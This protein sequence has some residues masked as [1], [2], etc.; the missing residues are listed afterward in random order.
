VFSLQ[1]AT[2]N[3]FLMEYITAGGFHRQDLP[4]TLLPEAIAMR[5]A[6]FAD[7]AALGTQIFTTHD[8]RLG[9][10]EYAFESI[11]ID[12]TTD[13][14]V[15]WC[16][17]LT[18]CD[19]ALVI[20]PESDDLLSDM[21]QLLEHTTAINLG[22]SHEAV[23]LASNKWF[24]YQ[25]FI[26][27]NIPTT[28]TYLLD[29][30]V[31][32]KGLQANQAYILKPKD[33]AG[34]ERTCLFPSLVAVM[35]WLESNEQSQQ[36][37]ILQPYITGE[38]A[39]FTML[40]KAGQAVVLSCN[41]QTIQIHQL[42]E[43]NHHIL[44]YHGGVVNAKPDLHDA[45]LTLAQ[46]IAMSCHGFNGLLGVDVI[47]QYS[48]RGELKHID[49]VEINPRITTSYVGLHA[50]IARNPAQLILDNLKDGLTFLY[51]HSTTKPIEILL[52]G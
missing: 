8:V 20:A 17:L 2:L 13:I 36:D 24:T 31:I 35:V 32:I 50:S 40:C 28:T 18:R 43:T 30:L 37:Y 6:I 19:Y 22:C 29:D 1:K 48:Q 4:M 52:N 11:A 12:N 23:V 44:Q 16:A 41:T 42:A 9:S 33:G 45:F 26:T 25:H 15:V 5:D 3:L 27:H 51:R 14:E 10:S 47:V 39:S 49:V 21:T 7:F 34:C 38:P 46:N